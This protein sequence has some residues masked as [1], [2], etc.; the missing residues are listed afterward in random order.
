MK[1]VLWEDISYY[2]A[3]G[4]LVSITFK[5]NF[6]DVCLVIIYGNDN[7]IKEAHMEAICVSSSYMD[8]KRTDNHEAGSGI[9]YEAYVHS[10]SPLIE[11]MLSHKLQGIAGS[12]P[13]EASGQTIKH[14]EIIGEVSVN[15]LCEIVEFRAEGLPRPPTG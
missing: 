13:L 10:E 12:L 14:F 7:T 6:T 3:A 11:A 9:I 4:N 15:I 1:T 5:E 8:W 2:F